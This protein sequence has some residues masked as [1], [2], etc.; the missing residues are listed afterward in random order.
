MM[1][2]RPANLM[3]SEPVQCHGYS[4]HLGCSGL[5]SDVHL[6]VY[7]YFSGTFQLNVARMLLVQFVR[8]LTH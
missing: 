6:S 2:S 7:I 4:G 5:I 1:M 8:W 3:I